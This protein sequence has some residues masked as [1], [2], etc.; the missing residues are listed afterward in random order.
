MSSASSS[1]F[2]GS[3]TP[4]KQVRGRRRQGEA[5]QL[6]AEE[7]TAEQV[8]AGSQ[9]PV[10]QV[11][12]PSQAPATATGTGSTEAPDVDS[13]SE[14]DSDPEYEPHSDDSGENSEVVELRRHARK[15]KK[16]MRDT[17]S[18]IQRDST[19]PIPVELIANMEEQHPG[20]SR[21]AAGAQARSSVPPAIASGSAGGA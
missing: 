5:E 13:V 10:S 3:T 17:K 2:S 18:W 8:V 19:A 20:A 15:F 14:S 1:S 9:L 4:V 16:K 11:F 21:S 12:N 7:V 6:E